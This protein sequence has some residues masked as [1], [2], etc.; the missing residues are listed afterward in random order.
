MI[1]GDPAVD[2][3]RRVL[4][5]WD[6]KED[7]VGKLL[8]LTTSA[9]EALKPI[10]EWFKWWNHFEGEA[11]PPQAWGE[12]AKLIYTTEELEKP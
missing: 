12:L 7:L 9:R 4:D 5:R 6:R 8:P 2:A 10:R 11:L 1:E 3:V